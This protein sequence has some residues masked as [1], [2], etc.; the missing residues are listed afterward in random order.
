M[1]NLKISEMTY[2]TLDGGDLFPTINPAISSTTNY[3][4]AA[5]EIPVFIGISKWNADTI[6]QIGHV[7][8]YN[9]TINKGLF[10]VTN[11]TS[12]GN[13]P[14][15]TGYENYKSISLAFVKNE[16][17]IITI[18]SSYTT[19]YART[20]RL[21]FPAGIVPA[22]PYPDIYMFSVDTSFSTL[23]L[24]GAKLNFNVNATGQSPLISLRS[25]TLGSLVEG[26][27]IFTIEAWGTGVSV[28]GSRYVDFEIVV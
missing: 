4:T 13:S 1:G 8:I 23:F 22:A 3:S 26:S 17:T 21:Y 16:F 19:G 11:T 24:T 12:A 27:L 6:Y 15:G 2:K 28:F 9:G 25:V 7:V 20:G 14:E 10:L 18:D 5:A